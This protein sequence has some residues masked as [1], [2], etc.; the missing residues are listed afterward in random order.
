MKA[1]LVAYDRVAEATAEF[2]FEVQAPFSFE[3]GQTCELTLPS[4]RYEDADWD[5]V[6]RSRSRPRP[7]MRRASRSATRLTGTRLQALA[8]R[9]R[10]SGSRSISTGRSAH[11]C[12]TGTP[13]SRLSSSRAASGL[14][15]FGASSRTQPSG[16]PPHVMTLLF[17]NRML[18]ERRLPARLR[19]V[20]AAEPELPAGRDYYRSR[21]AASR[22]ATRWA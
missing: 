6:A 4:P 1:R 10:R 13:P 20:A 9:G 5:R 21:R 19:G 3:A 18:G 17:S 2:T 22:G 16:G 14:R 7:R 12:C 8:S 15:R 11:S